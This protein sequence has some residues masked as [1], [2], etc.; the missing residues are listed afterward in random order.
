MNNAVKSELFPQAVKGF[1]GSLVSI[2]QA[3]SAI[4]LYQLYNLIRDYF[5]I[6]LIYV[7]FS[8]NSFILC[9]IIY[10]MLP[11]GRGTSLADLQMKFNQ[12][13]RPSS[14][15]AVESNGKKL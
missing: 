3:S 2:G 9:L 14:T 12:I 15:F 8:I 1:C 7:V 10:F 11:E 4:V 6:Y 13:P 5:H